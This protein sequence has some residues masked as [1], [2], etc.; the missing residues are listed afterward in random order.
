MSKTL[1]QA[2]CILGRQPALGLAELESLYGAEH[3]SA[4]A[5]QAAGLD[6]HAHDI[7]FKRLGGSTRLA[8]VLAVLPN[9]DWK[10]IERELP[11]LVT[12]LALTLPDGK[13]Q[14]GMSAFNLNLSP[15]KLNAAGLTLKKVLR[16]KVSRSVRITPNKE[17]ELNTASVLHNRLTGPTGIEL[18]LIAA[19]DGSTVI[20]RTTAVQDIDSY[21]LRDRGR[22]K[23]DAR[24]GM[25]P[26][27]LAQIIINL[28]VGQQRPSKD[29]T[30]LDPFC[31]TGVVLQ[32]TMLM[33]YSAAGSDIEQRMG[34]YTL[35]NL[36]WLWQQFPQTQNVYRGWQLGDA[37]TLQWETSKFIEKSGQVVDVQRVP[38]QISAVAGET[39]LGRPFTAAPSAEVLAQTTSEVNL[40]LKKFLQNI[41]GQLQ[42]GTRLCLA[43]P[44]W[45]TKNE[46]KHLPLI[47][48]ISD[49]GYNRIRFEHARDTQLLYYR[50]D[51]IVARELLVLTRK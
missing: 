26:P 28:A 2:I 50:E 21:T 24:V 35:A 3:V 1:P 46:F 23:R 6:L 33:G 30:V 16:N 37:T 13:I 45:H 12:E 44:A 51:Q 7:D 39:Y 29:F 5:P 41:H 32:E 22:P 36:D 49:L 42:P 10:R 15:A 25:L 34:D 14:L 17:P 8:H 19:S 31:G 9:T 18:L 38:A 27:K 40:I 43:V 47:D 11:T 20:A 48:Q 4:V